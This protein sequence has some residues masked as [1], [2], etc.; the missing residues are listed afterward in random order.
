MLCVNDGLQS[1]ARKTN[2]QVTPTATATHYNDFYVI[3][4]FFSRF[5]FITNLVHFS[6]FEY[7]GAHF[8]GL[9]LQSALSLK[10]YT[11]KI[12]YWK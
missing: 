5:L 4:F 2:L 6:D 8:W 9:F 7:L 11:K 10:Q 12:D 3:L 1:L